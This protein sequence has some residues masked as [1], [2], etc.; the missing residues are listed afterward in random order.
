[1]T[2]Q[3]FGGPPQY[4]RIAADRLL[5]APRSPARRCWPRSSRASAPGAGQRVETSLLQACSRCS[6]GR[7]VDYPGQRGRLPRRPRPIASTR[8]GDGEWFFL[9]VGNQSFWVK[10]CK[11]LGLED[12]ADDPR[13]G[14]WLARRD[15]AEALM[16]LLEEAFAS[17]PAAR[18][19]ARCW[20]RTTSR[21]RRP[22]RS[23]SSC[24]TPR[25][26][27]HEMVVEYDHPERGPAH[28]DGPAA[29]LLRDAGPR[30]G[31]AAR[32]SAS[33]P[34]QVLREAGLRRPRDRRPAPPRRRG[35][36]GH[37]PR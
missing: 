37:L 27:H 36:Q 32:C 1:M 26:C 5:H 19:A 20:P 30:R 33:T 29:P 22:R 18:V 11:A 34:P 3:G 35:R 13:F 9:A 25:C 10:L 8:R 6:P 2:L 28:P 7:G 23:R 14:S 21:P 12:L 17:R 4:L 15:N 16:P 24:A 31:A